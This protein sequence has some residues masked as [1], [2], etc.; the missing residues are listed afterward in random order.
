[1]EE[2]IGTVT[3]GNWKALV[4]EHKLPG[5]YTVQYLNEAGN[6]I[7]EE[8]LTGVSSYHQR[9]SEIA[10]RLRELRGGSKPDEGAELADSGEY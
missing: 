10:Q 6:V 5:E 7:E 2:P 3:D 1:M 9:E 4:Y 8:P